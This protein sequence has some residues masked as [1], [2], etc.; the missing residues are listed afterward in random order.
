[1][2]T[3]VFLAP[4]EAAGQR[5]DSWL[6]GMLPELSRAAVQ[7]LLEAGEVSQKGSPLP[8]NHRLRGGE[9]ITVHL[10]PPTEETALPQNIPLDIYYEDD[11]LLVVNKPKGMVVHPAAG[12]LDGTLVNALLYHCAGKLSGIGGVLRPGI[13]HRIDKDTSGLL[14]VAKNDA[15]HRGLAEQIAAHTITR[16]Y[17]AVVYGRLREEEQTISL[18]IGRNPVRRKEMAVRPD[19]KPAVTHI[20]VI[21]RYQGFTHIRARLETG[22]T[23]QIRVHMAQIGHSVV[24]DPVYGPKKCIT[25]LGGQCLHASD[26]GFHHP[27]TGEYLAFHAD[28]P[29]VFLEFL[30]SLRPE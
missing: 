4:P 25:R 5:L 21:G 26:L 20:S 16:C 13:V 7:R 18:P 15:A 12:N 8:K 19:G 29:P 9:E 24:G 3:M 22:R 28:P 27:I 6:T 1:M 14:V 2:N 23:H 17:E 11:A 30:N 10:P